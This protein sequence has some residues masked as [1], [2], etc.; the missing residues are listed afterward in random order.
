M[1]PFCRSP[2]FFLSLLLSPLAS[3]PSLH[4]PALLL[5]AHT[6]T[7]TQ[8]YTHTQTHAQLSARLV[9]EHRPGVLGPCLGPGRREAAPGR[10]GGAFTAPGSRAPAPGL[11]RVQAGPGRGLRP[12]QRQRQG[13]GPGQ[14]Q[15][16]AASRGGGGLCL[17]GAGRWLCS[18]SLFDALLVEQYHLADNVTQ[19]SAFRRKSRNPRPFRAPG[20]AAG[21]PPSPLPNPPLSLHPD[22]GRGKSHCCCPCNPAAVE[23]GN[24]PTTPPGQ[25]LVPGQQTMALARCRRALPPSPAPEQRGGPGLAPPAR[26]RLPVPGGEEGWDR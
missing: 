5:P 19:M 21:A 13:P 17:A 12:G 23:E 25:A 2:R 10:A 9:A 22:A 16:P 6:R 7:R 26:P 18:T 8:C 20:A 3:F 11:L 15:P 4:R 24:H 14:E 1:S